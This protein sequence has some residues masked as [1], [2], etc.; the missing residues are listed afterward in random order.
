V[1]CL[2]LLS[3]LPDW[4]L[5][6]VDAATEWALCIALGGKRA[7]LRDAQ[8]HPTGERVLYS[9]VGALDPN[10]NL[11]DPR[12]LCVPASQQER[13]LSFPSPTTAGWG[14]AAFMAL[15][16]KLAYE[17]RL[18]GCVCKLGCMCVTAAAMAMAQ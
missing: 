1:L 2:G 13:E 3:M 10:F 16:M 6:S 12:L 9:V 4:V 8:G 5:G 15:C 11:P 17:V 14:N 7:K 18:C